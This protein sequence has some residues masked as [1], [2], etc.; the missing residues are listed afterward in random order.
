MTCAEYAHRGA[1]PLIA[2][3]MLAG[4][5]VLITFRPGG[6]AERSVWA[7][8]LV[9]VWIAQNVVLVASSMWRL[10]LYVDV[11]SLTRWRVAA[12]VWMILIAIGLTL[13]IARIVRRMNNRWLV[14]VN[15]LAAGLVLYV[16]CFINFNRL[17]AEYNV[18][19][20]RELTSSVEAQR[21]E[22][23]LAYLESLGPDAIPAL[24]RY[25]GSVDAQAHDE[26]VI[27][28]WR[29]IALLHADLDR[30]LGDWR[31]WTVTRA[32]LAATKEPQ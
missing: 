8:R 18:T 11:Y 29:R 19:H 22:L 6:L 3:T 26:K 25:T 21:V 17:I 2:T 7:R 12:A 32:S 24:L 9:Y 16:C 31:G 30:Q 27:D 13:L 28:A 20:C 4:L 23:D 15:T 1:Y 5:F 10:S 14:Q